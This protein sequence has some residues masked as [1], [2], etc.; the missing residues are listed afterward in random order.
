MWPTALLLGDSQTQLAWQAGGWAQNLAE[1]FVRR[2]D[3]INRGFSGYNTRMIQTILP[4]IFTPETLKRAKIVCI[5]LGSNDASMVETNPEQ[6][7][8]VEEFGENLLK[9]ISYILSNGVSKQALVIISPPPILPEKWNATLSL[10]PGP[11]LPNCKSNELTKT[12]AKECGE[13]AKRFN[14][15]FVD[16]FSHMMD[17][18]NKI[19]LNAALSD[20]LHLGKEGHDALFSLLSPVFNAKLGGSSDIMLPEWRDLDNANTAGSYKEWKSNSN[21]RF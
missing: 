7:V 17:P 16:L 12:F 20:G 9:I 3:V 10:R 5:F 1:S 19:N 4:D 18:A 8:P 21:G 6:A 13:V 15:T 14:L 11:P 2:A